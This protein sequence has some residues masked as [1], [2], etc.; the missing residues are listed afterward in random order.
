MNPEV[1]LPQTFKDGIIK[2]LQ[3]DETH[4]NSPHGDLKLRQLL[5][6]DLK[7]NFGT[8]TTPENIIVYDG[9]KGNKHY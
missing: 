7:R 6:E 4:Y 3:N 8:D 5:C 1:P 2:A 9:P